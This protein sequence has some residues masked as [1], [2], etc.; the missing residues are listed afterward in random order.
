MIGG[1]LVPCG[2]G[3]SVCR[4][5]ADSEFNACIRVGDFNHNYELHGRGFKHMFIVEATPKADESPLLK[6]RL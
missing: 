5:G 2:P 6:M 1:K 4:D 3:V